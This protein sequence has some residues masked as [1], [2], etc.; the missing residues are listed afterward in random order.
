MP[1][2]SRIEVRGADKIILEVTNPKPAQSLIL[3]CEEMAV[4][5]EYGIYINGELAVSV[6]AED[7]VSGNGVQDGVHGV[8]LF[9]RRN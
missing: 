6:T 3:S 2:E 7:G 5:E 9:G 1:A 8:T 4:G